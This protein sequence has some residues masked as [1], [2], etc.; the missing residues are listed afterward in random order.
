M[1]KATIGLLVFASS[2]S[3]GCINK[4]Q[5]KINNTIEQASTNLDRLINANYT[6]IQNG[7]GTPYSSI[8]YINSDKLKDK[9]LSSITIDDIKDSVISNVVYNHP[10]FKDKYLHVYF[11]NGIV[12]NAV[13]DNFDYFTN[14]TIVPSEKLTDINY[15]L[16]FFRGDGS[17]FKDNFNVNTARNMF[18]DKNIDSFNNFYKTKTSNFVATNIKDNS[19]LYFYNLV[20]YNPESSST[21]NAT[22]NYQL[23][24]S[25]KLGV[26]NPINNNVIYINQ[27]DSKNLSEYSTTSLGVKTDENNNI[28]WIKILDKKETYNLINKSFNLKP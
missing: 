27:I 25:P 20:N 23:N 6:D 22:N 9:N 5:T 11:E 14:E 8:Y 16:E 26:V 1:K 10:D 21:I 18:V 19:K 7:F 2:L 12:K 13:T 4:D 15:K 24:S 17:L 3:V 28:K